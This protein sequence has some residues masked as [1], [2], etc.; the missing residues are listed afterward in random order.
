MAQ[1]SLQSVVSL[2]LANP[3]MSKNVDRRQ[4][5]K[6]P[7]TPGTFTGAKLLFHLTLHIARRSSEDANAQFPANLSAH[8]PSAW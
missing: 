6:N 3:E 2:V 8:H 5:Y 4:S 7:L 1:R